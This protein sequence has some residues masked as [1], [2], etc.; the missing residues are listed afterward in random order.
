MDSAFK[1]NYVTMFNGAR[2]HY[3]T[4]RQEIKKDQ[5]FT[6]DTQLS[7]Y[8]R[9]S[10]SCVTYDMYSV[11]QKLLCFRFFVKNVLP[12]STL[13]ED[14]KIPRKINFIEKKLNGG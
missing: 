2:Q 5:N 11:G 4:A 9:S 12:L 13:N 6:G 8:N 14:E 1:C 3:T 10:I 7:G